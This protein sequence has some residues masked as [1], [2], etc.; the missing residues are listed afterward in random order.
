[1]QLYYTLFPRKL[2]AFE[3]N[4]VYKFYLYI[5]PV[6][7]IR[8]DGVYISSMKTL[9]YDNGRNFFTVNYEITITPAS[10]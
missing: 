6:V 4:L 9:P 7:F 1:M 5:N 8:N 10:V 2:Q 3:N